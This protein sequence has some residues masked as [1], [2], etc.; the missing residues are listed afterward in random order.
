MYVCFSHVARTVALHLYL[1]LCVT[2]RAVCA[3]PLANSVCLRAPRRWTRGQPRELP[4]CS[5]S[6]ENIL[7][8]SCRG[9]R[10]CRDVR[11]P[12]VEVQDESLGRDVEE[13]AHSQSRPA[14]ATRKR[15]RAR[16]DD[17]LSMKFDAEDRKKAQCAHE[18]VHVLQVCN[19]SRTSLVMPG[20]H[21]CE[22]V[23]S[24]CLSAGLN[25]IP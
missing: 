13:N 8:A 16:C 17:R 3:S 12:H 4:R 23:V 15:P 24:E 22:S 14:A 21:V 9:A 7:R 19:V 5:T 25:L 20:M 1:R 10:S 18:R 11:H 6:R 2:F